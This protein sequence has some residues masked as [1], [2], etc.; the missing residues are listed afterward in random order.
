MK[1][2]LLGLTAAVVG[3][4]LILVLS[5]NP[6]QTN[7]NIV[8]PAKLPSTQ[9]SIEN[10]PSESVKGAIATFSGD[11][12]WES[13]TATAPAL[14]ASPAPIQQGEKLVTGDNGK[15]A[16]IFPG[17]TRITISPKADLD[18]IQTLPTSVV[19]RQNSGPVNYQKLSQP[20]LSVRALHLLVGI[21]SGDI[22]I[23]VDSDNAKVSVSVSEGSVTAAFNDLRNVSNELSVPAGKKLNFDDQTRET[24]LVTLQRP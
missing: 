14:L 1:S 21:N 8:S 13:R 16:V 22:D 23:N 18:I 4:I 2:L 9:F 7:Q 19:F 20:P 3:F 12:K 24:S 10:S 15:G 17:E 11:F 6:P 5:G